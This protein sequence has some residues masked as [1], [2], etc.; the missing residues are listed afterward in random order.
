MFLL[1]TASSRPALE[2][3]QPPMQW[4]QGTLSP[5][6]K[7][8]GRNA[9]HSPPSSAVVKN[10]WS[11]ISTNQYALMAWCSVKAK[12][13]LYLLL[14]TDLKTCKWKTKK[15]VITK[16]LWSAEKRKE[17]KGTGMTYLCS[18]R[19]EILRKWENLRKNKKKSHLNRLPSL[20]IGLRY[21]DV[22]RFTGYIQQNGEFET[23]WK[24]SRPILRYN[25]SVC[26]ER[27]R[28]TSGQPRLKPGSS[29]IRS[30]SARHYTWSYGTGKC[31][32]L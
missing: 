22:Y 18:I 19:T 17:R 26:M 6:V 23:M 27:L 5:G 24:W 8:S 30:K 4:V 32:Y 11:F 21:G 20:C 7:R 29:C 2:P 9:D 14:N 15:Q 16:N 13:Q 10:A 25:I 28:K 31:S 12:G 3:T 1:T